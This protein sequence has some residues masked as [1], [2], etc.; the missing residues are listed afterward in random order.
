MKKKRSNQGSALLLA[1][2]VVL[3]AAGLGGSFLIV[4]I[5][6]SRT[7]QNMSDQDELMVMCDAGLERAKQALDMY[8]DD[9]KPSDTYV[10]PVGGQ[11][12]AWNDIITYCDA[13]IP[14]KPANYWDPP[15]M[16]AIMED[17]LKAMND[18]SHPQYKQFNT[19]ASTVAWQSTEKLTGLW[20]KNTIQA[21]LTVPAD[22]T[23]PNSSHPVS[24]NTF[25]GWNIPFHKGAVHVY[26]HNNG[27]TKTDPT[28]GL[29]K[30]H[31]LYGVPCV[32]TQYEELDDVICITVTATLRSGPKAAQS[33]MG[34]I[35]RQIEALYRRPEYKPPS[36]TSFAPG[37]AVTSADDIDTLGTVSI[38]GRD[39][40]ADGNNLVGPGV[41]GLL[42]VG[43]INVGGS[44]T[45][46][47][48]GNAPPKV[49]GASAG[50][51]MANGS[52]KF[53]DGYPKTPDDVL[54]TTK[55]SLK[56]AAIATGTYFT[57]EA[58]YNA[59][60]PAG[61]WSGKIVYVEFDPSPSFNVGSSTGY[62]ADPSILVVHNDAGTTSVKNTKGYFKGLLIAD[63]INHTSA[64]GGWIGAAY[65]LSP[66]AASGA[67]AFG[68]GNTPI[69]F[70][71]EALGN[72]PSITAPLDLTRT[73]DLVSIRRVQ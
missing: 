17:A 69:K 68:T 53:P 46:G 64:P 44:S 11:K 34:G 24:N 32:D 54:K 38:D 31:G 70:S 27:G 42:S 4:N 58:A 65:L 1:V 45:I 19:Y 15:D 6:N 30:K 29:P 39:W 62:N 52:S 40:S 28:T 48:S 73:S 23:K 7:Q 9:F 2:I 8:R 20:G 18:S 12:W 57:S 59:A 37:A 10:P 50:S 25:I 41:F 16:H 22:K 36:P 51:T 71:S 43:N 33:R 13:N 5:T 66:T 61:G 3:L 60:M 35:V 72:L 49:K 56:L 26:I 55:G 63:E 47:G 67:N 14:L 21:E